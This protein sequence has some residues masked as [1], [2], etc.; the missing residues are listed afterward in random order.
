MS[1]EQ[2]NVALNIAGIAGGLVS[3]AVAITWFLV[4]HTHIARAEFD[5][6]VDGH[7]KTH[8]RIEAR[9]ARGDLHFERIEKDVDHHPG[10]ADLNSIHDDVA[11]L[12]AAVR[13]TGATIDAQDRRM[14]R[15]ET[16]VDR[17][18]DFHLKGGT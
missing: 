12:K 11:E 9:L 1:P 15:I 7:A 13:E 3:G 10:H 4:R 16:A 17:I 2:I 6:F 14:A 5:E 8:D 18:L